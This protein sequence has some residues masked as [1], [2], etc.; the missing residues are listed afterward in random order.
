MTVE[1]PEEI[2]DDDERFSYQWF[3]ENYPN[4]EVLTPNTLLST[5]L[6]SFA[7]IWVHVDQT[8]L[9]PGTNNLPASLIEESVVNTLST[10]YKE[11]G[12]FLLTNHATQYIASL[13]RLATDRSP[14]IFSSGEGGSGSDVWSINPNIGMIYDNSDHPVFESMGRVN[15]FGFPTIPLIGAGYREDHNS[16]WDLNS[17]SYTAPGDNVVEKFQNENSVRILATWGHVTDFCCAG[18]I[19]FYPT[20]EYKGRCI[21]IGLAAYEWNQNSGSNVYQD[22]IELLTSNILRYL[23][24]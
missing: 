24:Q 7:I 22:Q 9:Q 20:P 18:M 3:T 15:N 21:A 6:S 8:G 2:V 13:G 4:G 19:E 5:D 1:T 12:N 10:Y 17:Y 23:Q 16:M 14:G 11:G